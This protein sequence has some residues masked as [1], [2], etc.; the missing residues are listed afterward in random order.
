MSLDKSLKIRDALRRHRNVLTRSERV[1]RMTA[2]DRWVEGQ[3]VFGLQ[4]TKVRRLVTKRP[5][6]VK[7]EEGEPGVE[8]EG[9]AEAAPDKKAD[10]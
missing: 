1:Q 3:S 9:V 8:G 6:A 10:A 7:A 4:K 5:K 2:E